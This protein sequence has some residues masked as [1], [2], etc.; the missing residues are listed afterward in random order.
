MIFYGENKYLPIKCIDSSSSIKL[1]TVHW[2]WNE[3]EIEWKWNR[4][5]E[6]SWVNRY[7]LLVL[8]LVRWFVGFTATEISLSS[9]P[10]A[11]KSCFC[12]FFFF[13]FRLQTNTL[14]F[15]NF[16]VNSETK[17]SETLFVLCSVCN[18]EKKTI[19]GLKSKRV[20]VSKIK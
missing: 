1:N 13:F 17:E 15:L 3:P 6:S 10:I 12:H 16:P 19:F 2:K 18:G 4:L 14:L 20:K 5:I 11:T 9:I 7:I 8:L